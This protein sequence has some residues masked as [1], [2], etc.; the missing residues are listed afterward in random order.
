MAK[1]ANVDKDLVIN[2]TKSLS[3]ESQGGKMAGKIY[4]RFQQ[5]HQLLLLVKFIKCGNVSVG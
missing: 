3:Q 5:G 2:R 4:L 1:S